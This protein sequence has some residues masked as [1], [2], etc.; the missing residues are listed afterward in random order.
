MGI[1]GGNLRAA[2]MAGLPVATLALVSAALGGAAAG[3]AGA[4]EIVAVHGAASVSLVVG[5]GYAGILVA[6]IA[7]QNPLAVV[8]VALLVGGISAS[9]GLLQRR[10]AMPDAATTVLEGCIFV[11]VLASNAIYGRWR[12]LQPRLAA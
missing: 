2:Q 7:R 8:P 10:F 6:F 5:Y 1:L 9:G 12:F 3:L 11:V 4:F